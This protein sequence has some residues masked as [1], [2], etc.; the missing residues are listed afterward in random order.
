M[1]EDGRQKGDESAKNEEQDKK[2]V[3]GAKEVFEELH[4]TKS[5][6][7]SQINAYCKKLRPV[8]KVVAL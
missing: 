8:G 5:E 6:I 7:I 4:G 2:N 1:L 3:S